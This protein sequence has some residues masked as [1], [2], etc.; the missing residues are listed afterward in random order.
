MREAAAQEKFERAR[1]SSRPNIRPGKDFKHSFLF[2]EPNYETGLL[3]IQNH[4]NLGKIPKRIEGYDI[5]NIQGAQA[6]GSMVVFIN[7]QP[8]KSEYR[9]FKIKTKSTPDDYAMM[10]E[11]LTRRLMHTDWGMPDLLFIDGGKGQLNVAK[12]VVETLNL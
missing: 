11:V 1:E 12:A 6:S 3:E 7:G 2:T 8:D 9:K 4:L 5:S 10:R